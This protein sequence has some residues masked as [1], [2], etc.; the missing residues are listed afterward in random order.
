MRRQQIKQKTENKI[1]CHVRGGDLWPSRIHTIFNNLNSHPDYSPLPINYYKRAVEISGKEPYIIIEKA[2]TPKWYR[3]LFIDAFGK[4]NVYF[5]TSVTDDFFL[6]YSGSEVVMSLSS[7][8]WMASFLGD[9]K[10]IHF[11]I[12][13]FFDKN[14]RPDL[15]LNCLYKE[16]DFYSFEEC[17]KENKLEFRDWLIW[18][19]PLKL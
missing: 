14:R 6:I 11:P 16:T 10:K 17:N 3:K 12:H 18:S 13:G 15:S 7:F 9:S 5:S 19:N 8:S 4:E 1:V 2:R